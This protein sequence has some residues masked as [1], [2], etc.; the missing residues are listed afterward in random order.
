ME[1]NGII[2]SSTNDTTTI[3]SSRANAVLIEKKS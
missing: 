3:T 1:L 2:A